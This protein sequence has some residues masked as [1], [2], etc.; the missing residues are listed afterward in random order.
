MGD[1]EL[2]DVILSE[3]GLQTF[4]E[5]RWALS[6]DVS[7]LHCSHN[8]WQCK[9]MAIDVGPLNLKC[10][11]QGDI[12]HSDGL[13]VLKKMISNFSNSLLI[14]PLAGKMS[15]M[16]RGILS[17]WML[18]CLQF[19]VPLLW[20]VIVTSL[21]KLVKRCNGVWN[22]FLSHLGSR[23]PINIPSNAVCCCTPCV[24][25]YDHILPI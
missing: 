2:V 17:V 22:I 10:H 4:W 20:I 15:G 23:I 18:D 21:F 13:K 24:S 25:L 11:L 1:D 9:E 6:L 3:H 8:S 16:I 12:L 7:L 14:T 19:S 5:Y